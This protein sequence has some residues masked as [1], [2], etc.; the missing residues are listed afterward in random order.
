MTERAPA[1]AKDDPDELLRALHDDLLAHVHG[2]LTDDA[3]AVAI[4]RLAL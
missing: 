2:H 1:W 3:A 4:S